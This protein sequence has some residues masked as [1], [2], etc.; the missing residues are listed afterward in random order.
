MI[1]LE[2]EVMEQKD[3]DLAAVKQQLST[4]E[5]DSQKRIYELENQLADALSSATAASG[6]LCVFK[7]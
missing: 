6:K 5:S 4:L 7:S 2:Q 1:C 3:R